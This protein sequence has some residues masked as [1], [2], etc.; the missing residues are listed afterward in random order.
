MNRNKK[1][2]SFQSFLLALLLV[3]VGHSLAAEVPASVLES[4]LKQLYPNTQVTSVAASEL[5]GLFEVVMGKNIAYRHERLSAPDSSRLLP[6][7]ICLYP[8][9]RER[10]VFAL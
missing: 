9:A 4:R 10:P 1:H 6:G 8:N 3:S 2:S 5:P 7:R